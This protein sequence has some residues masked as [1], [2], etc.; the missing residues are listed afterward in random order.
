MGG[1]PGEGQPGWRN[2]VSSFEVTGEHFPPSTEQRVSG[3]PICSLLPRGPWRPPPGMLPSTDHPGAAS[4]VPQT[5]RLRCPG[6][7]RLRF[8]PNARVWSVQVWEPEVRAWGVQTWEQEVPLGAGCRP[9]P[10]QPSPGMCLAA[11]SWRHSCRPEASRAGS[12]REVLPSIL[13][14]SGGHPPSSKTKPAK[15]NDIFPPQSSSSLPQDLSSFQPR[16]SSQGL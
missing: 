6:Q 16:T 4:S 1:E 11:D 5:A 3:P 15:G 14:P 12:Y 8:S 2:G 9:P 10:L 7:T 13:L